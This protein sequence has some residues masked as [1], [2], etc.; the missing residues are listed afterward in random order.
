MR[1]PET[2]LVTP[3]NGPQPAGKPDECFYCKQPVGSLH[4]PDCVARERSIVVRYSFEIVIRYPESATP[5]G[6]EH[7]RNWSGWCAD[8]ALAELDCGYGCLCSR[9]HAEFVREATQNEEDKW[10]LGFEKK[11]NNE[12]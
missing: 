4:K 12:I 3:E 5:E 9:F 11:G 2:H 10:N 8:N 7:H 6:F 1:H